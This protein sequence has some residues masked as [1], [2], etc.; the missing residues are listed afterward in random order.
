L[1]PSPL[2]FSELFIILGGI[3]SGHVLLAGTLAVLI[4]LAFIGLLHAL[5]EALQGSPSQDHQPAATIR[6]G[7]TA[8][9]LM[10]TVVT[11]IALAALTACAWLLP[12]SGIVRHLAQG[13]S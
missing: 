8:P 4:A 10:P 6:T 2:F 5:L 1:P 7:R 11:A 13:I 9:I 3:E 12:A